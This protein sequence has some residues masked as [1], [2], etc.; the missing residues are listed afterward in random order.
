HPEIPFII[1]DGTANGM[2]IAALDPS[3]LRDRV[4]LSGWFGDKV[5]S[6]D[7]DP[8]RFEDYR[9]ENFNGLYLTEFRLWRGFIHL[10]APF[11][12][13][14]DLPDIVTI[15][16][17]AS[18]APWDYAPAGDPAYSRPICRRII[19]ET[20]IARNAFALEKLGT[21][22]SGREARYTAETRRDI[23]AWLR[24]RDPGPRGLVI[25]LTSACRDALDSGLEAFV[26][27]IARCLPA[28][29][30]LRENLWRAL[31]RWRRDRFHRV[32]AVGWA[33]EEATTR[34]G[35]ANPKR[36]EK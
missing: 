5:W 32:D 9:G 18:M 7:S 22:A 21:M 10:P 1:G 14:A 36:P 12:G 28:R 15:S 27:P 23:R 4:L 8:K 2:E 19:E 16:R 11:L 17:S 6:R 3:I 29:S 26:G 31:L 35:P 34:Y 33:M 30:R 20:G 13:V 25:S 24:R